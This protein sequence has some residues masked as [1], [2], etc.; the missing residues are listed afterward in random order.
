MSSTRAILK[1]TLRKWSLITIRGQAGSF[2][3]WENVLFRSNAK[4]GRILRK[5]RA[6]L[7][8]H[9]TVSVAGRQKA[10]H[11]LLGTRVFS[12]YI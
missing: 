2:W 12:S 11:V 1:A 4:S 9:S 7:T 6:G 3:R 5:E 10:A 8:H